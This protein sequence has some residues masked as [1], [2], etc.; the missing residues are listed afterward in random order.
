MRWFQILV[1]CLSL[2]VMTSCTVN[3]LA[4]LDAIVVAAEIAIP[5]IAGVSPADAG[6]VSQYLNSGLSIA[7]NLMM[8]GASQAGIQEAILAFQS[9]VVPQVS[10]AEARAIMQDSAT[11]ILNFLKA[12]QM[13]Q[14]AAA[15]LRAGRLSNAP[16]LNNAEKTSALM[17]RVDAAR[18]KLRLRIP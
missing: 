8:N 9:L 11:A 17:A 6:A 15:T 12:F 5:H 1:L 18:S 14:A 4:L 13:P 16:T 10:S 2:V 3:T 7:A